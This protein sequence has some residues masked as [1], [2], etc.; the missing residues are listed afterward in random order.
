MHRAPAWAN[1]GMAAPD[2]ENPLLKRTTRFQLQTVDEPCSGVSAAVDSSGAMR[3]LL[4]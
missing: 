1:L 2:E 3:P 4:G